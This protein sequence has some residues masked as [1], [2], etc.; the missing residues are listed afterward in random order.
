MSSLFEGFRESAERRREAIAIDQLATTTYGELLQ[1]AHAI[2]SQLSGMTGAGPQPVA[3]LASHGRATLRGLL[4][5][6]GAGQIAV[7]LDERWAF[8]TLRERLLHSSSRIVLC[9]P[10]FLDIAGDLCDRR[11][12][13][14]NMDETENLNRGDTG[15]LPVPAAASNIGAIVYTSGS[16]GRPK[17]VMHTHASLTANARSHIRMLDLNDRDR[18]LLLAKASTISGL[19]DS[20]RVLLSGG[21]VV[22]HDLAAAGLSGL[23]TC[24][25]EASPTIA[26]FVPTIFRRLIERI[27]DVDP[28]RA[29]QSVRV[30][31]LGG[32]TVTRR[33]FELYCRYCSD[34]CVLLHNLG[35][36]EVP[37]FRHSFLCKTSVLETDALPLDDD[38]EGKAA[39]LIDLETGKPVLDTGRSA[40]IAVRSR[41]SA[42]G[43]WRDAALSLRSFQTLPTGETVYRTG[44]IGR[45]VGRGAMV[46]LGRRDEQVKVL[47][48][49]L[50]LA[51]IEAELQ[52]HPHVL[53][54]AVVP[55]ESRDGTRLVAF[56]VGSPGLNPDSLRTVPLTSLEGS[57]PPQFVVL[58]ELPTLPSGKIDRKQLR[59][60]ALQIP[61]DSVEAH[62]GPLTATER[63]LAGLW[64][65]ALKVD[66]FRPDSHF[67]ESGGDSLLAVDLMLDIERTFDRRL[68]LND[69]IRHPTLRELAAQLDCSTRSVDRQR[70]LQVLR[71]GPDPILVVD[72][73]A[74]AQTLQRATDDCGIVLLSIPGLHETP[75]RYWSVERSI[76]TYCSEIAGAGLP[77]PSAIV[78][79]SYGGLLAYALAERLWKSGAR[80]EITLLIEPS[81]PLR[82]EPVSVES[83]GARPPHGRRRITRITRWRNWAYLI[84]YARLLLTNALRRPLQGGERWELFRSVIRSNRRSYVPRQFDGR[85]TLV[86]SARYLSSAQATWQGLVTGPFETVTCSEDLNHHAWFQPEYES[87]W[88][89]ALLEQCRLD[90]ESEASPI[91]AT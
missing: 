74:M 86:G 50:N 17:G 39:E 2:A 34:E 88:I 75:V 1:D 80:P 65:A 72:F 55:V 3:I 31:H 8:E 53:E 59:E 67:F 78:G 69:L 83:S 24:L 16:S 30:L 43:Y 19:T 77:S 38:S 5:I 29:F 45:W 21:T 85:V 35:C 87:R 89:G 52:R 13:L 68:T 14:L 81:T 71:P 20:L 60:M 49:Q 25:A 28:S 11:L 62:S 23:H 64:Q 91:K 22:P 76:E 63:R 47:G 15:S 48:R 56:C 9:E 66:K 40:E 41:C 33:D 54:G 10:G 70:Y 44:D 46:H 90:R 36:T 61:S 57:P 82:R 27:S 7:P 84:R 37:S 18:G 51:L 4:S 12:T 6:W 79:F 73:A 32:E 26:H 58:A 42:V